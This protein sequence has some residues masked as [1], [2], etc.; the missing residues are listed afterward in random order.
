[1]RSLGD[2]VISN[3]IRAYQERDGE[4]DPRTSPSSRR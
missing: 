3:L 2:D 4:A 1:M